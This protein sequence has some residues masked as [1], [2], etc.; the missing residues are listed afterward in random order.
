VVA[1]VGDVALDGAESAVY[2]VV[3][4]SGGTAAGRHPLRG[5]VRPTLE[6]VVSESPAHLRMRY[7]PESGLAPIALDDDDGLRCRGEP[8]LARVPS[9]QSDL[10][11][12]QAQRL[13]EDERSPRSATE[14]GAGPGIAPEKRD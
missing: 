2:A 11:G 12:R 3:V 4:R 10:V 5:H 8:T 13:I 6:V 7:H 1:L 9:E 14:E